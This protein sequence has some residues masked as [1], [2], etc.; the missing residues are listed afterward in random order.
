MADGLHYK[1][2]EGDDM[3]GGDD[4]K[5]AAEEAFPDDDWTP[6]RLDALKALIKLCMDEGH[7]EPDGDEGGD[8]KKTGLALIFGGKPKK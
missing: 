7:D 4:Y 2:D 1:P 5:Q 6:D 3:G 8:D